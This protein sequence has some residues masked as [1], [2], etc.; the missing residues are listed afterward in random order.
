[1]RSLSTR[2][3]L[4]GLGLVGLLGAPG[5]SSSPSLLGGDSVPD[6][7]T[8]PQ[9]GAG[10]DPGD[11]NGIVLPDSPAG[12]ELRWLLGLLNNGDAGAITDIAVAPHFN[13]FFLQQVPA[14]PLA[15]Y[16][17][18]WA[19]TDAPLRLQRIESSGAGQ[20]G[21]G[22]VVVAVVETA[23]HLFVRVSLT[24]VTSG[25]R[26]IVGLVFAP[27]PAYDPDLVDP[28]AVGARLPSVAGE[29]R[30]LIAKLEDDTCAPIYALG[31]DQP[32]PLGSLSKM[33]VLGALA[34]KI[35]AGQA[36]WTDTITIEDDLKSLPAG[37][38]QDQPSGTKLSVEE[39]AGKMISISDNTAADH[40]IRFVG[41]ETIET[42]QAN[43]GHRLP[44]L[45]IPFLMTRELLILKVSASSDERT[46]FLD[47]SSEL[48]RD[49]LDNVYNRRNLP[50]LAA[51]GAW[52]A[53]IEID[54][55]EWFG[56]AADLCRGFAALKRLGELPTGAP[57][58]DILS[59]NP[60][61]PLDRT[62]FSYAGYKGGAE[63][64]VL[65]FGWLLRR[66]GDGAWVVVT[67]A[68]ADRA[69]PID[70]FLGLYYALAAVQI[71]GR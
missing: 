24:V 29:A 54:R 5:C 37:G 47:G 10:T 58:L 44:A 2:P 40:L 36:S 8:L 9:A 27:A 50:T 11:V 68:F 6:E 39:V 7:G 45:N 31:A 28:S 67:I 66:S 23:R 46:V 48:R 63:P 35:A 15:A 21:F 1:M 52:I 49:L 59:S 26:R 43:M 30:L 38:L 57:V 4:V 33:Y 16:L 71:A 61:M 69:K 34:A 12:T 42:N 32:M 22:S 51:A 18:G 20:L 56:S 55:L 13:A 70:E 14:G 19:A 53:P 60:G 25:S 3:V 17:S 62:T 41:R 65:A 64:G